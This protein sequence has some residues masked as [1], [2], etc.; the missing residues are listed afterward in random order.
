MIKTLFESI[1]NEHIN[2]RCNSVAN[3]CLEYAVGA[4]YATYREKLANY[5]V[6]YDI[7]LPP[8]NKPVYDIFL[9]NINNSKDKFYLQVKNFK[10]D[11]RINGKLTA[12]LAKGAE[13]M[14]IKSD[15]VILITYNNEV[16]GDIYKED[17]IT[18]LKIEPFIDY[19]DKNNDDSDNMRWLEHTLSKLNYLMENELQPCNLL[20]KCSKAKAEHKGKF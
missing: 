1:R 13:N 16:C 2:H 17:K 7:E 15:K 18:C 20:L 19:L 9:K 8:L 11:K 6:Y 14:F 4:I 10:G 3:T 5:K 12:A